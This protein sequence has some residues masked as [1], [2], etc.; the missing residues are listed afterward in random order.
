[1]ARAQ[2]AASVRG[3]GALTA[4]HRRH[5]GDQGGD[6]SGGD[7]DDLSYAGY[8]YSYGDVE[9]VWLAEVAGDNSTQINCATSK[10]ALC[11]I[12]MCSHTDSTS[13]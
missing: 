2:R 8:S 13:P 6:D 3:G 11:N 9:S 7:D 4:Q 5:R 1:M 12:A 10:F